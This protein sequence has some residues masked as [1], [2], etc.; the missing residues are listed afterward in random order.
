MVRDSSFPAV[1]QFLD[2]Q[3]RN[4]HSSFR[5]IRKLFKYMRRNL[6]KNGLCDLALHPGMRGGLDMT[7]AERQ[8]PPDSY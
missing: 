3:S 6:I 8:Y 4:S 7:N 2:S 1:A 5:L